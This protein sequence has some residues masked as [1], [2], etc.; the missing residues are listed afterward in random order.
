MVTAQQTGRALLA[1]YAGSFF[2]LSLLQMVA[3]ATPLWGTHLGLSAFMLGLAAGLRSI[4]PLIYSVHFGALMD[5]LGVRRVMLFFAALCALLPLCYPLIPNPVAFMILQLALGLAAATIWLASQTAIARLAAGDARRTGVFSFC[6]ST[7]AVLGPLLLGWIW[8][9][10]GGQAGYSLIAAW[11]AV[12]FLIS[13]VMPARRDRKRL[14]S[15][16]VFIPRLDTYLEAMRVL[17]QPLAAFVV[18]CAFLRLGS[19]SMLESFYPVLLQGVG[20]SAAAIGTLFA[21]GNLV[22][23]PSVLV[24]DHWTRLFGSPR[25]ALAAAVALTILGVTIAPFLHGFWML[26]AG[27]AIYGFG[28]GVSMPIIFTLL[29]S[30]ISAETQG[31][32]AGVRATANRLASV[33]L[34][35]TMGLVVQMWDV[36]EA[37]WIVGGVLL[38]IAWLTERRYRLRVA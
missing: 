31:L 14:L 9:Q 32:T 10:G 13:L 29:S 23:S 1:T 16:E 6:T 22:S 25:Q 38:T 18:I 35:I 30:G 33:V 11:G 37:F 27:M 3:L 26:A 36:A 8:D 34:P 4:T 12:L 5:V 17:K 21:I 15:W 24:A 19:L 7:G 2:S 28:L 20:Y